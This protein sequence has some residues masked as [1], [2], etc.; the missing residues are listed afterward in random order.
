MILYYHAVIFSFHRVILTS[1]TMN[2]RLFP[3]IVLRQVQRDRQPSR[4]KMSPANRQTNPPKQQH[5]LQLAQQHMSQ[6]QHHRK[7]KLP[8][9]IISLL[10]VLN[11]QQ[12]MLAT[13]AAQIIDAKS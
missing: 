9:V 2:S 12:M 7:Q 6:P 4:S 5:Q 10:T 1:T 11:R 3:L 8:A 13:A